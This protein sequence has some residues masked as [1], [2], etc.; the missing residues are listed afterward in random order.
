[1]SAFYQFVEADRVAEESGAATPLALRYV[2]FGGE[3]LDLRQL[4]GW[5]DR[6]AEDAPLLVNM[7]GITETTVHVSY[8]ALDRSLADGASASVIGRPIP[9]LGAYVLD[10]RLHPVPVGMPG[11]IYVRGEQ[12][13]RGYLGRP[14]LTSARFV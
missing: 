5:Y 12:L 3:A 14:D 7:Y 11:E 2:I 4:G 13:T 6:H 10:E 1:P 9:G 8:L